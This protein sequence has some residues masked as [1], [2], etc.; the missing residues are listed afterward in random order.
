MAQT[1][2]TFGCILTMATVLITGGT[3]LIGKALTTE[4][5]T[6]GHKVIVLTRQSNLKGSDRE[7]I[8]YAQWDITAQTIDPKAIEKA[9]YIIHLAGANVAE[10]RWTDKRKK[11]IRE[12]RTKSGSLLV[13]ALKEYPN[14]VKAVLSASAIGWYGPDPVVPNTKPFVEE[15]SAYEDFLGATCKAWEQ[16]I[17]PI[18]SL[19]KRLVI[20]RTGIV[21]SNEGGAYKEFKRPLQ[22]GMASVL[23]SGK[24]V[25]SWIHITDLVRMYTTAMEGEQWHGI[26]NAVAPNPVTNKELILTIARQ[27]GGFYITTK[28]PELALKTALGEMSVEVLKSSTVSSKKAEATGFQFFFPNIEVA[29]NNLIKKAS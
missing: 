22:F 16:S 11:E 1:F 20:L 12:S 6:K 14:S 27:K 17:E 15:D 21:L 24:Q 8:Q 23:G 19:G 9:D 18:S 25:V 26:Y 2:P 5:V 3:G 28:V 7:G 4:L 10:G 13:K 29:V